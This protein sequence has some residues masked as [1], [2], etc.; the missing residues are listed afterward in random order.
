MICDEAEPNT[1]S[2]TKASI[3]SQE[4]VITAKDNSDK[5]LISLDKLKKLS[6]IFNSKK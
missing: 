6:K 4:K 5:K 3:S 1:E 2:T